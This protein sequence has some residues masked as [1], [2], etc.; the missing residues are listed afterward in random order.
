M[1]TF[2][3]H[4]PPAMSL[5]YL[6]DRVGRACRNNDERVTTNVLD[7]IKGLE[8]NKVTHYKGLW[9]KG[10]HYRVRKLDENRKTID[11]GIAT[12]FIV[13]FQS[14]VRD[15][16]IKTDTLRYYGLIEDILELNFRSFKV[17]LFEAKWFRNIVVG[18]HPTTYM[19]ENGFCIINHTRFEQTD[20]PYVFP[21]QCEQIFLCCHPTERSKSFVIEYN[22][23]SIRVFQP[24][25]EEQPISAEMSSNG[26]SDDE[27][28]GQED[29]LEMYNGYSND[30]DD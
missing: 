23:R 29:M 2:E 1:R 6:R 24:S 19:H 20:E 14:H 25:H 11:C 18:N 7:I 9:C 10:R 27:F 26:S 21:D 16:N 8:E 5:K 3:K 28:N 12:Y 22:P 17:V 4:W 13:D 15:G 30:F